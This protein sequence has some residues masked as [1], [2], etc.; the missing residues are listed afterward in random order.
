MCIRDRPWFVIPL[1][2]Q[3]E[4]EVYCVG[5][6]ELDAFYHFPEEGVRIIALLRE[7]LSA[8]GIRARLH[9]DGFD[10]VDV[11]DFIGTL[12]EIGFVLPAAERDRF[13]ATIA[14][15]EASDRRLRFSLPAGVARA[16]FSW[17]TFAL[18]LACL[19]YTSRCV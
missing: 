8:D 19:L 12:Q 6:R 3:R 14:E 17:P 13:A 16:L 1:S 2:V 10:D 5:N 7:G 18:Y 15:A 4:G 11:D 9:D